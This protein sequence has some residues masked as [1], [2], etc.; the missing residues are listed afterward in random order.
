MTIHMPSLRDVTFEEERE[1]H[2]AYLVV[3][4][5]YAAPDGQRFGG[6]ARVRSSHVLPSELSAART[7]LY[8]QAFNEVHRA[9]QKHRAVVEPIPND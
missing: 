3:R 9:V 4:A 2:G 1:E 5:S 6:L 7:A 8:R